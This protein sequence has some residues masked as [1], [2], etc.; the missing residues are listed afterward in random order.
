MSSGA[1]S[2]HFDAATAW[3]Y[4]L[5]MGGRGRRDPLFQ[6]DFREL[7]IAAI[8]SKLWPKLFSVAKSLLQVVMCDWEA[9]ENKRMC[10]GSGRRQNQ[11][12]FSCAFLF[13][14][15]VQFD[16]AYVF[17]DALDRSE[18]GPTS[19]HAII[20]D[21]ALSRVQPREAMRLEIIQSEQICI[22]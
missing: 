5:L 12:Q 18:Q 17:R 14:C 22:Q 11:A 13:L 1:F 2:P 3:N 4:R 15:R 8:H 10:L 19:F 20:H 9:L 16:S 6:L 21:A 7:L